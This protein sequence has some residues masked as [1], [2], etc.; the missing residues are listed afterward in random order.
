MT[1]KFAAGKS[2]LAVG[3]LALSAIATA[4]DATPASFESLDANNDG[5]ISVLEARKDKTVAGHF[6]SADTNQDGYL[7]RKEFEAIS[8]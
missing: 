6:A 3:L 7:D 1:V 5:R 8:K 2:M 4:L